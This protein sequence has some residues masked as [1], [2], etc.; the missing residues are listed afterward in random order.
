MDVMRVI[1]FGLQNGRITSGRE[2]FSGQL[3]VADPTW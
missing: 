3:G 1:A 2:R